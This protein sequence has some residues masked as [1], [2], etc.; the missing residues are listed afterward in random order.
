MEAG[1]FLAARDTLGAAM[2]DL[3]GVELDTARTMLA[4]VNQTV[5]FSG[6]RFADDKFG[7]TYKVQPGDRLQRIAAEHDVTWELLCRINGMTDPK[8][9][10]AGATIKVIRGPFHAVVN[11][12]D[13]RL[14]LYLG[15][16]GGPGSVYVRSLPVGLG[17]D[18]STPTG[19]WL[20]APD[21]KLKNPK[22]WGAAELSPME[23]DDPKNPLGEFWLG[24]VGTEGQAVGSEG[25][26]IHGTLE[27]DS[28]GKQASH[29]CIRLRNGDIDLVYEALI[30]DKSVVVVAE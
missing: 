16:P 7:G 30:E 6:R 15:A 5:V 3:S 19:K 21:N 29:G 24:L 2:P 20:V 14:D 12:R 9:L 1:Q 17:R 18:D 23:A 8:R 11:K 22:F 26:G 4:E 10:R 13:F 28:I 25:Y 27:P